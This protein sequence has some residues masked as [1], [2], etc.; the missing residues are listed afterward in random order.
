MQY[1]LLSDIVL[2]F[3]FCPQVLFVVFVFAS[4]LS[5]C[6]QAFFLHSSSPG[7][8]QSCPG[9]PPAIKTL[10]ISEGTHKVGCPYFVNPV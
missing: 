6:P 9:W 2:A 4:V 3:L 7:D 1:A 5:F 8:L 10:L